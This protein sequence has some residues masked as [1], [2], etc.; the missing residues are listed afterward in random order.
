MFYATTNSVCHGIRAYCA[1]YK[2]LKTLDGL[3]S[4][5]NKGDDSIPAPLTSSLPFIQLS[6][7]TSTEVSTHTLSI[8]L[9]VSGPL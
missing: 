5:A 3:L 4:N 1:I 6:H 8:K 7:N 9:A 2:I